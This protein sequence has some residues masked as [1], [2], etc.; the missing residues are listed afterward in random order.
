MLGLNR[1]HLLKGLAAV[2]CFVGIASIAL[3]YF[4]PAPPSTISM[5]VGFKGGSYGS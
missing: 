5:A 3:L 4:F 2:L 1:W